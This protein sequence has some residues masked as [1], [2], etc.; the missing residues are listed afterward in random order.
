MNQGPGWVLLM[1]KNGGGKSRASVP[2]TTKYSKSF[3]I[4]FVI[5]SIIVFS[6]EGIR[7]S[8]YTNLYRIPRY[9]TVNN[10]AELCEIKSIPYIR[11]LRNFKK[12]LPK[13]PY[14]SAIKEALRFSLFTF[15]MSRILLN[16]HSKYGRSCSILSYRR[17]EQHKR[18]SLCKQ[19]SS[20]HILNA[21]LAD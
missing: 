3:Q 2:L 5:G 4:S 11:I 18:P 17:L 21:H 15:K 20:C 16:A 12:A 19:I 9:W 13:T 6:F 8:V 7:N 14:S 10:F 1:K